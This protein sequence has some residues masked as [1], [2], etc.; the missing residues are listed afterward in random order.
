M[1]ESMLQTGIRKSP[2]AGDWIETC[3]P[4]T[5]Q[6][7]CKSPHAGDWI[8]THSNQCIR[9][10]PEVPSRRGLDRNIG[11]DYQYTVNM[12]SPHAGDWIETHQVSLLIGPSKVPSRRGLDRNIEKLKAYEQEKVPSRRGLDRN[13]NL[14]IE[15][16]LRFKSPH[17]GDW[18]ETICPFRTSLASKVPSRRGL[19]RNV[20]LR[21]PF[22][23]SQ[24]PSRRGLDRNNMYDS[25]EYR[26]ASPLTQG[27][28]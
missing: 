21:P 15:H 28:G 11:H 20:F 7:F 17:A 4:L 14:G 12:K 25:I 24:V 8:E 2:H 10:R 6:R 3:I 18:I 23:D 19:D 9:S 5:D 16:S 1:Y 27:T 13:C 26:T 22:T